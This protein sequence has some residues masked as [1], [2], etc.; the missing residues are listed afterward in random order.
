[1]AIFKLRR[2]LLKEESY[3]GI[4]KI[5]RKTI[6]YILNSL[7]KI[8]FIKIIFKNLGNQFTVGFNK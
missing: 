4:G 5:D 7:E 3:L 2:E 1:M 8:G 6:F